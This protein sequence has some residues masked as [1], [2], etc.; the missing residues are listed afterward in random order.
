MTRT[1]TRVWLQKQIELAQKMHIKGERHLYYDGMM[2][3]YKQ[4]AKKLDV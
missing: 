2:V 1:E 4:V 3:A